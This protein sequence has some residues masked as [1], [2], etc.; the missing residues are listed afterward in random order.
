M[1]EAGP[2]RALYMQRTFTERI[3]IQREWLL[4]N[5]KRALPEDTRYMV[6]TP[7][8]SP[9]M[10]LESTPLMKIGSDYMF[11][12]VPFSQP[13][14]WT[15]SRG[16]ASLSYSIMLAKDI[17]DHTL[18][19]PPHRR[20]S[21]QVR[22]FSEQHVH[23]YTDDHYGIY[24]YGSLNSVG[25]GDSPIC[26]VDVRLSQQTA[27]V[28][29]LC[30]GQLQEKWVLRA[31]CEDLDLQLAGT[32]ITRYLFYKYKHEG[33]TKHRGQLV[34]T[35]TRLPRDLNPKADLFTAINTKEDRYAGGFLLLPQE[36]Y[37]IWLDHVLWCYPACYV[38]SWVTRESS[39]W[40]A[41]LILCSRT[42]NKVG[43][44]NYQH[45]DTEWCEFHLVTA[46]ST[47]LVE[48][49]FPFLGEVKLVKNRRRYDIPL[50]KEES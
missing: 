48:D 28:Y 5:Y 50:L 26:Y 8:F 23:R 21:V 32:Q 31:L 2:L 24:Y 10:F 16:D 6:Y 25:Q 12:Y 20:S 43:P 47:K 19:K 22:H 41:H 42:M 35:G 46:Q 38:K 14:I 30:I 36:G 34:E 44:I 18:L 33:Y 45:D 49:A 7:A 15:L 3:I 1:A 9:E 39:H 11:Y 40:E 27:Y 13:Y 4:R 37:I 17:E 29:L